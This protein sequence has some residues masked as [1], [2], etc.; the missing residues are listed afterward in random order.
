MQ[1]NY[2]LTTAISADIVDLYTYNGLINGFIFLLLY[3]G[4]Y[5][6]KPQDKRVKYILLAMIIVLSTSYILNLMYI[7]R[8]PIYHAIISGVLILLSALFLYLPTGIDFR[9]RRITFILTFIILSLIQTNL[10]F[11]LFS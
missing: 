1:W 4:S 3:F 11:H 10:I 6:M 5:S 8:F 7:I 2:L 9:I